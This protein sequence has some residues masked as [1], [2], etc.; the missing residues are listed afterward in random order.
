MDMDA[1]LTAKPSLVLDLSQEELALLLRLLN[2]PGLPGFTVPENFGGIEADVA[3]RSLRARALLASVNANQ[4]TIDETVAAL[5]ACGAVAARLLS[6]V[7]VLES[8]KHAAAWFY[9][10]PQLTV[11]HLPT[12]DGIHHFQTVP[13]GVSFMLLAASVLKIDPR[14]AEK[15]DTPEFILPKALWDAATEGFNNA[16]FDEAGELLRANGVEE[17]FILAFMNPRR[18]VVS[19]VNVQGVENIHAFGILVL[20]A[21]NGYWL[22]LPE[23]DNLRSVPEN[24]NGV[25]NRVADMLT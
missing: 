24:S 14:D 4:Y 16:Q 6:I 11:L 8:Q 10:A 18:R 2:I 19:V 7:N 20:E 13:D 5:I 9:L 3:E 23:Q 12:G 25:L 17:S 22:L 1:T 15:P 21:D